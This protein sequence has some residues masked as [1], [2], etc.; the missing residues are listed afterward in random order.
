MDPSFVPMEEPQKETEPRAS[1]P[2]VVVLSSATI[3]VFVGAIILFGS[4]KSSQADPFNSFNLFG[5][6]KPTGQVAGSSTIE[7][8]VPTPSPSNTPIPP[9]PSTPT[10]TTIPTSGD[11]ATPTQTP[12]TP[13]TDTPT[14]A[15]TD[16][17]P[18]DTPT[19]TPEASITPS[20]TPSATIIPT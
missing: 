19:A 14:P 1:F 13:P 16:V 5:R 2:L 4:G 18:T 12:T 10:S 11:T 8:G 7:T 17:P 9:A 15:P 3:I 20:A 6:P